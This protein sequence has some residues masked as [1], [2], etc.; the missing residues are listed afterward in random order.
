[1]ANLSYAKFHGNLKDLVGLFGL[2]FVGYWLHLTL[3]V[4]FL[5]HLI[6]FFFVKRLQKNYCRKEERKEGDEDTF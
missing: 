4:F 5:H 2:G 1:M 3:F 6:S